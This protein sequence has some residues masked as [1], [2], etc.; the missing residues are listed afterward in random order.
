MINLHN[1]FFTP[2]QSKK[3]N[4]FHEPSNRAPSICDLLKQK[5]DEVWKELNVI[6]YNNFND[7]LTEIV[8]NIIEKLDKIEATEQ[9]HIYCSALRKAWVDSMIA[10][11]KAQ[12]N[13]KNPP[14][15]IAFQ[16]TAILTRFGIAIY[17]DKSVSDPFQ[18]SLDVL[19]TALLMQ[20]YAL[21]LI[22]RCPDLSNLR[23]IDDL[24]NLPEVYEV[25]RPLADY[26]IDNLKPVTWS[27]KTFLLTEKQQI[28]ISELLRYIN[29]SMRH[30]EQ[31]TLP[32]SELLLQTAVACLKAAQT[33]KHYNQ[34]EVNNCLAELKYNDI[35]CLIAHQIIEFQTRGETQKA[36]EKKED[37]KRLWEDCVLL[38]KNLIK[39][40]LVVKTN[41]FL[42][43]NSHYRCKWN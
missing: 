5:I 36:E 11:K 18:S 15:Q 19:K 8:Q 9:K 20:Y 2:T 4:I 6:I 38:S 27:A 21:G 34:I 10:L 33:K 26:G 17:A 30:L 42:L 23:I 32:K 22:H 35:S 3:Q 13:P 31:L 24:Y 29:G 25:I 39:C 41:A 40:M 14:K 16:L 12:I 7:P 28:N 37:L 43:K 1:I